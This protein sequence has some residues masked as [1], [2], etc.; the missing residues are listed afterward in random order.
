MP[1]STKRP[2]VVENNGSIVE[3]KKKQKTDVALVK[4]KSKVRGFASMATRLG[5]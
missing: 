3:V 2:F 5:K 1:D 4:T